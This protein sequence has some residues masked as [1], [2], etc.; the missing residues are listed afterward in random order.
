MTQHDMALHNM[1][2]HNMTQHD[3]H[4]T[5]Y[6]MTWHDTTTCHYM[7]WQHDMMSWQ[8]DMTWNSITGHN[9]T[10]HDIQCIQKVFKSTWRTLRLSHCFY[11]TVEK[12]C[13]TLIIYLYN[14][15]CSISCS[16]RISVAS[17]VILCCLIMKNVRYHTLNYSICLFYHSVKSPQVAIKELICLPPVDCSKAGGKKVNNKWNHNSLS[18]KMNSQK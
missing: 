1:K 7:T 10:W 15:L 16:R 8:H 2:R 3:W 5:W 13:I 18:F 14:A 6:N 17:L 9:M 4:M 11:N 12:Q